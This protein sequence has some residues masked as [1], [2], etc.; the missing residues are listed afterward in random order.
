MPGTET[1]SVVSFTTP[2]SSGTVRFYTRTR[3][4]SPCAL[5]KRIFIT[6]ELTAGDIGGIT[7]ADAFCQASAARAGLA[8][9]WQA[10]LGST[11]RGLATAQVT[12]GDYCDAFTNRLILSNRA[13]VGAFTKFSD[14]I[15]TNGSNSRE[16]SAPNAARYNNHRESGS[17]WYGSDANCSCDEWTSTAATATCSSPGYGRFSALTFVDPTWKYFQLMT[18]GAGISQCANP[19]HLVCFE[20]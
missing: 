2:S 13:F 15:S 3:I 9:T 6:G 17:Y 11:A 4:A 5:A 20:R 16:S 12:A 10:F 8:G 18:G 14:G 7:G 1:T 19:M